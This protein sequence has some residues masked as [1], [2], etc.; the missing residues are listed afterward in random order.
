MKLLLDDM[1]RTLTDLFQ[2]GLAT[3]GPEMA[4]RMEDLS[5][6]CGDTGLHTGAALFAEISQLLSE[7]SHQFQ[8]SDLQIT[9]A[10]C[11]AA[12]YITLCRTR[13]TEDHIRAGWQKGGPK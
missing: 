8:K 1:E 7:R 12:H 6:R 5:R 9:A 3:A 10:I 4:K 11:R 2:M 13:L